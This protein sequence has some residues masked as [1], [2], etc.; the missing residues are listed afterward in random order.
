MTSEP[1][2]H[3]L[4]E[5]FGRPATA[6]AESVNRAARERLAS[7]L[8]VPLEHAGRCILLRAPRAGHGKTHMLSRVEQQL[9]GTHEFIAMHAVAGSRVDAATVMNDALRS[10]ARPLAAGGGLCALDLVA[11]R[12]FALA[13][14]PLVMSGE[15]PSYDRESAL[16]ALRLRPV[17]TFDFHHP[18]A[19][20]AHWARENFAVLGP[21]LALGLAEAT[22]LSPREVGVW[23]DLMFRCAATPP[24][25]PGRIGLLV[26][27]ASGMA[28]G[29][30]QAMERLAA[31]LGLVALLGRVVLVADDLEVFSMDDGAAL[32]LAGFLGTLRQ[33]VEQLDVVISL[34][35]DIWR[36]AFLPRLCDGLADRLSEVVID[37][38][39]LGQDEMVALLDSRVPGL[40]AR[41]LQYLDPVESGK[42]A[43]GVMRAAAEV[44]ERAAR[45]E[46]LVVVSA[47]V[48]PSEV[49]SVTVADEPVS[50]VE[51]PIEEVLNEAGV[52]EPAPEPPPEAPPIEE[53]ACTEAAAEIPESV[54]PPLPPRPIVPDFAS[55]PSMDAWQAATEPFAPFGEL[56]AES[57]PLAPEPQELVGVD[58]D[59][60]D[61]LLRR[62]RERY[63][64]GGL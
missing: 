37:L 45:G 39:P 62:F 4:F 43:R 55:A 44:W 57:E 40:G 21:R 22:G 26:D 38:E 14:Q 35:D 3:T 50:A 5:S 49:P 63:G 64:R 13:M 36:S 12:L 25:H 9:A 61:D 11:R 27:A 19:V 41:V 58:S 15:V 31:L 8:A 42:H 34:N 60:V 16:A 48:A 24:D 33:A 30:G 29:E 53:V 20:T 2:F 32:R 59:R 1:P 51:S 28:G 47:L 46:T 54:E 6:H 52:I 17:E 18:M 56:V 10:L 23:V 7:V